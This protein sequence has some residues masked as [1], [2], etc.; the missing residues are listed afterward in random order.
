MTSAMS[1]GC[2]AQDPDACMLHDWCHC[3]STELVAHHSARRLHAPV[4]GMSWVCMR[5][6]RER[7]T[8]RP[9]AAL[10][11]PPGTT[12]AHRRSLRGRQ[13]PAAARTA[14]RRRQRT[15]T[16]CAHGPPKWRGAMGLIERR[17]RQA[18]AAAAAAAAAAVAVRQMMASPTCRWMTCK[19]N[20]PGGE[21]P[22]A[23]EEM[24]VRRA[25]TAC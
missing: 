6:D 4:S 18:V 15:S 1:S 13:P 16:P 2:V 24:S 3:D 23:S 11:S 17:S 14:S 21:Q 19:R 25:V 22:R 9:A 12:S 7:T 20:W 5:C 8:L 10:S